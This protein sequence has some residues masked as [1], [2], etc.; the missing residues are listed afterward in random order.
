MVDLS[1]CVGP[2][3]NVTVR[4]LESHAKG[5]E[6]GDIVLIR[7]NYSDNYYYNTDFIKYSPG[8]EVK[9]LRWLVD[10][11][12][13]MIITD[14]ASLEKSPQTLSSSLEGQAVLSSAGVPAVLCASHMWM[15]QKQRFFV[16]CSPLPL[17]GLNAAPCRVIA[18]EEWE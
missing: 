3:Q 11:G 6:P 13:K 9:A 7:T 2:E 5:I 16:F 10:K 4:A 1:S 14:A 12:V 15:I 17:T 8:F 18:V